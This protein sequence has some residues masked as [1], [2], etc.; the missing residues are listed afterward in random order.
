MFDAGMPVTRSAWNYRKNCGGP[1]VEP[2]PGHQAQP[3]LVGMSGR[4]YW[5]QVRRRPL[6]AVGV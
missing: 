4:A 1:D 2:S 5:A 6:R 3:M